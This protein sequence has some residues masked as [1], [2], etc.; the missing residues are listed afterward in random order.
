MDIKKRENRNYDLIE[1]IQR[2]LI[3]QLIMYTLK[4]QNSRNGVRDLSGYLYLSILHNKSVTL[5]LDMT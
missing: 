1:D 4:N 3:L 5:I 2:E